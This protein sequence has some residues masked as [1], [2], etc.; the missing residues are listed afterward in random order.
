L[1]TLALEGKRNGIIVT[2]AD[3]FSFHAKKA[4]KQAE[5]QG[6]TIELIDKGKLNRMIS[7]LL[8]EAPWATLFE[9]PLFKD[10]DED[11]RKHFYEEINFRRH[12]TQQLTLFDL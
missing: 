12:N 10:V 9:H 2:S 11:I 5:Q 4:T 7:P 1:G 6:Y 8:P 3:Y